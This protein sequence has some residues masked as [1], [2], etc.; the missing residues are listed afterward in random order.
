MYSYLISAIVSTYNSELFFR[1]KIED[2]LSQSIK[3]KLEIV[4][5]VSGS[6]QNELK[7]AE[8]FSAKFKNIK[9]IV[10]EQRENI[11]TAWNRGIRTTNSKY[12]TNAN[13]DDRLRPDALEKMTDYLDEHND[14][15]LIYA[16]QYY[17]SVPNET[18]STI[19]KKDKY[20]KPDYNRFLLLERCII[21]SQPVWR[22]S[23]HFKDG[24]FFDEKY[25]VAGDYE[26]ELNIAKKY[27]LAHLPEILGVYFKS[28]DK[29]NK[30]YE[31]SDKT[32]LETFT[33]MAYYINDYITEIDEEKLQNL[34]TKIEFKLRIP[35][36]IYNYF[37][38]YINIIN[39]R[40][41]INSRQFLALFL[42]YCYQYLGD[43]IKAMKVCEKYLKIS[44]STLL[45]KRLSVLN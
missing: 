24:Y 17:S 41:E 26:F 29:T 34:V 27:K 16:D 36:H 33:I 10:T 45:K 14:V 25:E 32:F 39:P 40:I 20:L 13:T 30:E 15:Y 8:E 6:K 5:V 35:R 22:S 19:K 42:S 3:D 7:I 1:G 28:P 4:I 18:F 21:G 9:V 23:L 2:L 43:N 44:E 12:I 31:N 38:K 11:Y 37:R